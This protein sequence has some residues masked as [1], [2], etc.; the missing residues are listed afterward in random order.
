MLSFVKILMRSPF[1]SHFQSPARA[2]LAFSSVTILRGIPDPPALRG[3]P[4][5]KDPPSQ[6][7]VAPAPPPPLSSRK[8]ATFL[9]RRSQVLS[10]LL[11]GCLRSHFFICE[12]NRLPLSPSYKISPYHHDLYGPL[13]LTTTTNRIPRRSFFP[14][15]V[16]P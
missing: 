3:D 1:P 16:T 12:R 13:V 9:R 11:P 4:T 6:H 14:Y 10:L 2:R 15:G 7:F 8:V 5:T